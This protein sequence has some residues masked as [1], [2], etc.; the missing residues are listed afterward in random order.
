MRIK[1]FEPGTELR[2][3]WVDITQDAAWHTEKQREQCKPTLVKTLGMY[4]RTKKNS[5]LLCH[6]WTEDGD[7]DILVIPWGCITCI[8][9]ISEN[10]GDLNW[11][12]QQK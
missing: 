2:V 12:R 1:K 11:Q 6:S 3:W 8:E 9:V 5:L 10:K 4:I 7:S